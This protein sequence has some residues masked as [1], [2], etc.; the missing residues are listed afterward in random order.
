MT[1]YGLDVSDRQAGIDLAAVFADLRRRSGNVPWLYIKA[2]EGTGNVQDTFAGFREQATYEGF[3]PIGLYHFARPENGN[4]IAEADHYLA[5]VGNFLPWEFPV[6]DIET[7]DPSTWA[8]FIRRWCGRVFDATGRSPALYMSESP[9]QSMPA[10]CATWPLIVA[11]YPSKIATAW[12]AEWEDWQIGLWLS[13]VAW[14]WTSSNS[15]PPVDGWAGRLDLDIA[16][17]D[18]EPRL[19][20][21]GCL[22]SRSKPKPST[23]EVPHVRI[24]ATES[25]NADNDPSTPDDNRLRYDLTMCHASG[26]SAGPGLVYRSEIYLT[27]KYRA[28]DRAAGAVVYQWG[29]EP[30]E[31]TISG[32]GT[33][34]VPVTSDGAVAVLAVVNAEPLVVEYDELIV[35]G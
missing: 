24:V 29:Q 16:P 2:T 14:Q 7:G 25:P 11:G 12:P 4:P 1:R 9:A 10:D 33:V 6:L 35:P 31:L 20:A 28:A 21:A 34:T 22:T 32:G 5:T 17:D 8:D 27:R 26:S 18:F 23:P 13:P 3:R 19:I 30:S 15:L